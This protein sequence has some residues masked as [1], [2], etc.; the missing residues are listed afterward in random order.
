MPLPGPVKATIQTGCQMLFEKKSER[1]TLW[2]EWTPILAVWLWRFISKTEKNYW[3]PSKRSWFS[4]GPNLQGVQ[5][6]KGG[7]SQVPKDVFGTLKYRSRLTWLSP[8]PNLQGEQ[9]EGAPCCETDIVCWKDLLHLVKRKKK[10]KIE[11][12]VWW[13]VF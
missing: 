11:H 2:E 8:G 12:V 6:E 13:W 3:R 7:K 10:K 9:A 4:P 1:R 5:A